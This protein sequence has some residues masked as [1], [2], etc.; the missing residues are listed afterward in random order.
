MEIGFEIEGWYKDP[1]RLH[2]DRWFSN[3]TAT[4]LVRDG[5]VTSRDDPPAE[6]LDGT[7]VP[8]DEVP[9]PNETVRAGDEPPPV[10]PTAFENVMGLSAD[11]WGAHTRPV[12]PP[13]FDW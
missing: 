4:S 12:P 8:S 6:T 5:D 10:P 2:T 13:P 3:G 1:F 7:L 11:D 9:V